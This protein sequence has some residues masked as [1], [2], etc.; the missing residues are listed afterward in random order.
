[1]NM[2]NIHV[3]SVTVRAQI[4]IPIRFFRR[5][6]TKVLQALVGARIAILISRCVIFAPKNVTSGPSHVV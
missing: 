3:L 2:T 6:M 1:M 4:A 5:N